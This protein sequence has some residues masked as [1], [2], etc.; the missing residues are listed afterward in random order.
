MKNISISV[1]IASLNNPSSQLPTHTNLVWDLSV[2]DL[3]IGQAGSK[4]APFSTKPLT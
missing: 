2:A 4:S 1:Q 3:E